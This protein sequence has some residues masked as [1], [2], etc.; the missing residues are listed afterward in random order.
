MGW[1]HPKREIKSPGSPIQNGNKKGS[2]NS[3]GLLEARKAS[4][5]KRMQLNERQQTKANDGK[6]RKNV[7]KEADARRGATRPARSEGPTRQGTT[8]TETDWREK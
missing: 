1:H 2:A 8:A 4:R 6:Y 5:G 3:Q 7:L